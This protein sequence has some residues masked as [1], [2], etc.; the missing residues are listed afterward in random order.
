MSPKK[1][2]KSKTTGNKAKKKST[3]PKNTVKANADEQPATQP[4]AAM[5]AGFA[6]PL[7]LLPMADLAPESVQAYRVKWDW[8]IEEFE[9]GVR[10]VAPAPCVFRCGE[11][12]NHLNGHFTPLNRAWQFFWFDL[13]CHVVFGKFHGELEKKDFERLADKWTGVGGTTTAFMNNGNGLDVRRN[14][15]KEIQTD[16]R[17]AA[18]YTLVCGGATLTGTPV[19][20]ANNRMMLNVDHFDGTQPPPPVETV[21]PFTDPRVYFA[22]IIGTKKVADGFKVFPFPQFKGKDVPIPLVASTDIFFPLDLLVKLENA[23]KPRPYFP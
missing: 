19:K 15:V 17:D 23:Q 3:K 14:Y 10:D 1:T 2:K 6:S 7:S 11:L 20:N 4:E 22:T 9:G 5:G 8:E 12:N 21:D 13:C 16:Q 18:I